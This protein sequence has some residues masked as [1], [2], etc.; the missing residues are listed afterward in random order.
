MFDAFFSP[1]LL[2]FVS[3]LV[4]SGAFA[5]RVGGVIMGQILF[6]GAMSILGKTF[7]AA[8]L[9][10]FLLGKLSIMWKRTVGCAQSQFKCI[11]LAGGVSVALW[12]YCEAIN[13]FATQ[14]AG[15]LTAVFV[16]H[17]LWK[18]LHNRSHVSVY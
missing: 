13:A 1:L 16:G 18:Q 7:C 2:G 15:P 17:L 3:N 9:T 8:G 11:N 6:P 10:S 12:S 4:D 14:L 5:L